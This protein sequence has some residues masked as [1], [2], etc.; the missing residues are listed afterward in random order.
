MIVAHPDDEDG[1]LLTYLSRGMGARATLFTLNRGEGGQNAMTADTY[2]AL[3]LIRTNELLKANEYNGAKQLWG[4]EADFGFSK[5]RRS[6]SR[7]GGTTA[8][9]MTQCLPCGR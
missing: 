8:F 6:R 5:R 7:S 9:S 1:A 4:T 3:G 2:D